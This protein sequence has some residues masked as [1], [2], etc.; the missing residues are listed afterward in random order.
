MP[1]SDERDFPYDSYDEAYYQRI[2]HEAEQGW[3]SHL[4]RLRWLDALLDVQPGDHI[5]DLGSGAGNICRHLAER[6]ASVE[7]VD[8]APESIAVARRRCEG[9]PV[10]LTVCDASDCAHLE[11]NIFDKATCCDLI[12]HVHDETMA[13]VFREAR[14]LL[15]PGGVMFVY[16]PNR[17]HWIERLKARNFILKNPEGHIRVRPIPEVAAALAQ[18]GFEIARV[19]RPASMLPVIQWVEWLW[20]RQPITPDLAIY[21]A[22]ILAR[23]PP[24]PAAT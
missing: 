21:R 17:R 7:G 3:R 9:L 16:S 5:V 18:C 20:I 19:A 11:S 8:L 10:H 1:S 24:A 15:K 6:G 4:W 23:K 12:E 13:G 2:V 14:R 22:A